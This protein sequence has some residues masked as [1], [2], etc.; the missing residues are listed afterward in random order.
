MALSLSPEE[1]YKCCK[2][3]I[4]KFNT[5]EEIDIFE[6]TIGQEKAFKAI[7]FGLSLNSKGFNIFALGENGTGRMRTIRA[8][9][10][11]K[12][13]KE[14]IPNDWCYVYN[15]KDPDTPIAIS[16][17]PGVGKEFQ[18][19]MDILIKTIRE[20]M[21]KVFESKEYDKQRNKIIE[22]FQQKQKAL[23]TNLEEDAQSKGFAIRK[24][25]SG[26]LIIPTKKT[27]EPLSEEEFAAL[28]EATKKR[29]EEIGS[30]LQEKL[31]DIGRAVR[32]AEKIL[33]EML[34]R[35]EREIA[36]EALD[37]RIDDLIKKYENIEKI[38]P[39]LSSVQDDILS[40]LDDFKSQE[41]PPSPLPFMKMPKPE[42]SFTKY[43]V[44]LIVD[45]SESK[46]APV[47]FESNPTY[48]NLF[49]RIEHKVQF[50]MAVTDF[51]MIKAGSIH[52][53]NG[54]YIVIQGVELFKNLFSYD[55]L[56]R[57]IK[58]RE[59]KIE[60]V[61]EQYRLLSTVTMKPEPIP[62]NIK[63]ILI[64]NPYMYYILYNLDEEYKELFKVK[65]DFDNRM[66]RSPE[67]IDKYAA[68]IATCQ[69]E[70][71]LKPFDRSGVAKIIEYS[72]RLAGH[73]EKL[74]T[75]FSDIVD[76]LREA[77]YWANKDGS[78]IVSSKN[79][80]T[81]INE[82]IY[83]SNR[84]E[85]RI[86]EMILEDTLIV[87]TEGSKVGQVNG[88]AVLDLGDYSFGKPSRITARTYIGKAGI[89]NIERE[90]KMSGRIHAKAIMIISSYLGSKYAANKPLSLSASITFE[91]L[92]DMVEGDSATCAE[93]Y[94]LLSSLSGVPLRQ[95]ISVTGSMD[96]NGDVQPIGGVN[97][98]IEGFF[99]LC[100]IRKLNGHGVIIPRR[101][102]KHLMLKQE[103]VDA[104]KDGKFFIYP[105]NK[106]EDGLEILT[107]MAA[108]E[109]KEY[110]AY[111][112]GTINYLVMKRLGEISDALEKKKEK[113]EEKEEKKKDVN[114]N[115]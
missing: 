30:S 3:D 99:D 110:A 90:T 67:N 45:N 68:F 2:T 54:G 66:Q 89:V 88:L 69:K 85:E 97:E 10:L 51:S 75:K 72:S 5:T 37:T 36:L 107:G 56:K 62:L 73:Q 60:D 113:E 24:A 6:E 41:E 82:K 49:G 64:G 4:F 100:K 111:P 95:D 55:A 35:L 65:A 20:E 17:P 104:V 32:E 63:V 47:I 33:K 12:A 109:I 19:D 81:A 106:M 61:W 48:L 18:K 43:S 96:Q 26:L 94:A 13:T 27:G 79:V 40:H 22:E 9:L 114:N 44:N 23:F 87:N 77:D 58:N 86:R 25:V 53:A 103:V 39:Y 1:L 28:D 16:L 31:D 59:I 115:N 14:N 46:G 92:Y 102:V 57:A 11:K 50:G 34:S 91:Q 52:K 84:I 78:S 42:I 15:F 108:G 101:N 83:R 76:I 80:L 105:I 29:I 21:V 93:L 71:G 98:K 8:L 70:E 7:D 38:V 112:E 74:S